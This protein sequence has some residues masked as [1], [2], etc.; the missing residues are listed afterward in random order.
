MTAS[1]TALQWLLIAVALQQGVYALAWLA[2]SRLTP[3]FRRSA[4][5]WALFCGMGALSCLLLT[6]R[7]RI[8]DVLGYSAA[9]LA[10]ILA[11]L[12][13]W[14]ASATFFHRSTHDREQAVILVAA[15]VVVLLLG[16]ASSAEN[17][18]IA[19]I[20]LPTGWVSIRAVQGV[21]RA[22]LTEFHA[23]ATWL[24]HA[25][26]LVFGLGMIGLGIGVLFGPP[27]HA[28][29]VLQTTL[30]NVLAVLGL[31]LM[32][33]FLSLVYGGFM[34]VRLVR[35]LSDI[36]L[37]DALTGLLNRRAAQELLE[38]EWTTYHQ[39][40]LPFCV[41]VID[42]DHFK[43]INDAYGHA[44][45]DRVLAGLAARLR[46]G[47][48]PSDRTARMGGEEFLVFLPQT[49]LGEAQAA[50]E[51]LRQH[52]ELWVLEP[53]H[54]AVTVSIGVAQAAPE[55]ETFDDLLIRAD[56]AL[57]AAKAEGRNRVHVA[58]SAPTDVGSLATA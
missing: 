19:L 51:R 10:M 55:D 8:P 25:P 20:A 54:L 33:S 57:Y 6:F 2:V 44:V 29:V 24:L 45:G 26:T 7:G 9:D 47:T 31:L 28:P 48:R 52:V 14:R 56:R 30:P 17:A 32:S 35:R 12:F 49:E 41:L 58:S 4:G 53:E 22:M 5:L 42:I 1:F 13:A 36:A 46:E 50:A 23:S 40:D 34:I 39:K 3:L 11:I 37:H 27:V 38:H 18:R 15:V 43:H 21:H 16:H